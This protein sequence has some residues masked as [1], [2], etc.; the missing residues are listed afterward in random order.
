MQY[1]LRHI[2]ASK[3]RKVWGVTIPEE[4]A[5][6]FDNCY[7]N[8]AKSGNCILLSSGAQINYSDE[9]IENY[10]FEDCEVKSEDNNS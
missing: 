9:E 1:K 4:I 10:E 2:V 3:S 8:I 5:I 7:F 6:F